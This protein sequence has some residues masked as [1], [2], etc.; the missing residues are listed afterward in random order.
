M[1]PL[2]CGVNEPAYRQPSGIVDP[3][4]VVTEAEMT[5]LS[6]GSAES[7]DPPTR[8]WWKTPAGAAA[9]TLTITAV[10]VGGYFGVDAL[11]HPSRQ[12]T[13]P[14]QTFH[15]TERVPEF[16]PPGAAPCPRIGVD[17]RDRLNKG[18]RGTPTTSCPFVEQVRRVY[19]AQGPD[20]SAPVQLRVVS[21][22][23]FKWYDVA[24]LSSPEYVTCTGGAAAVIYLYHE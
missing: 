6:T 16:L 15:A 11:L 24:C 18:A 20:P 4:N 21:P 7:G 23:T 12:K 10:A 9:A 19:S 8:P 2:A 14:P 1:P 13:T 3:N 22:A 5:E 17:A